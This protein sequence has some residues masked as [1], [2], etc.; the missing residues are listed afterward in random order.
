MLSGYRYRTVVAFRSDVLRAVL[1]FLVDEPEKYIGTGF[2]S[3]GRWVNAET[4]QWE[5]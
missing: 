3:L 2:P 1:G 4:K 5:N